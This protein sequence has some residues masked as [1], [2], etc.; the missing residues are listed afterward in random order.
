MTSRILEIADTAAKLHLDN[1][2]LVALFPDGNKVTMPVEEIG[3]LVL[4]NPAVSITGALL[5]SLAQQGCAVVVSNDR[6]LPIAMQMPLQGNCVQ[7]ERF[8]AQL[9]ASIPLKKQLWKT[10]VKAKVSN[11]AK[12]LNK[13]YNNDYGLLK[14]NETVRSGDPDNIEAQAARI[15]WSK[16]FG[17]P[18]KRDR[19]AD[20][21]NLMLNYGYSIL[22]AM[23][24]RACCS[25]GLHPTLGISHHNRYDA[26][27]LADDLMEPFRP[28][29]DCVVHKENPCN[30]PMELTRENRQKILLSLMEKQLMDGEMHPL[31]YIL[32]LRASQLV[33]SYESGE[34]LLSF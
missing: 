21:A 8:H 6:R 13:L 10:I 7:T 31:P 27:C 20:D 30:L 9:S 18:F 14:L 12:L 5:A 2:L 11:Q 22:R 1:H 29:I 32:E 25:A 16:L 28:I 24:A 34:N 17:Q 23:V 33:R 3:C 15:Y 26:F 19:E 4:A